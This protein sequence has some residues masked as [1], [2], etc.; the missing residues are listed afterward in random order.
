MFLTKTLKS[1]AA[2]VDLIAMT[3]ITPQMI[4]E[5]KLKSIKGS[6]FTTH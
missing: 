3:V 5:Y 2:G 4:Y 1:N 6:G